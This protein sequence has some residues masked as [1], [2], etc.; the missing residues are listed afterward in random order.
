MSTAPVLITSRDNPFIKALRR[1]AQD[2]VAYRKQG[3]VWLEGDHLCRAALLRGLQPATAVFSESFWTHPSV[4]WSSVAIKNIV[5]PDR[6]FAEVSG[7]N[8]RRRWVF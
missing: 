5:I 3:Q 6:L 4:D 8:L 7:W 2:S 1:L